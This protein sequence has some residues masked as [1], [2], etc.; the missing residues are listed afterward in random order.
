METDHQHSK[1]HIASTKGEKARVKSKAS[2]PKPRL[3]ER[4][5]HPSAE[6]SSSKAVCKKKSAKSP[7]AIPRSIVFHR[8]VEVKEEPESDDEVRVVLKKASVHDRLGPS[9]CAEELL[10]PS[11]GTVP[12]DELLRLNESELTGSLRTRRRRQSKTR[13]FL[14]EQGTAQEDIY[15]CYEWNARGSRKRSATDSM[16]ESGKKRR[17]CESK[18]DESSDGDAME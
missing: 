1:K 9:R 15:Y 11:R 7:V 6:R 10:L 13:K 4:P 8:S 3:P 5:R 17:G 18:S 2:L 16:G 12:Q 14:R